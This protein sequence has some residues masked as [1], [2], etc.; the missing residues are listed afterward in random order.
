MVRIMIGSSSEFHNKHRP[1]DHTSTQLTELKM[2]GNLHRGEDDGWILRQSET[3]IYEERSLRSLNRVR[4]VVV[5]S[6]CRQLAV[7]VCCA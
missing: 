6:S 3:L 2:E 1:I 4:G 5:R 7:F